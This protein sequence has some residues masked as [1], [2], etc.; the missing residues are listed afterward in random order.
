MKD[1]QTILNALINS[2]N[3]LMYL[4]M[5]VF[6]SIFIFALLGM[7]IF[8]GKLSFDDNPDNYPGTPR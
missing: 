4:Y 3:A 1:M 2:I 7:Q 8:G 6:L 5:L